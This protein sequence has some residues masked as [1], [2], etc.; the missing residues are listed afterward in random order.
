MPF[1]TYRTS[2][3]VLACVALVG[4]PLQAQ[5]PPPQADAMAIDERWRGFLGCWASSAAGT[6]GP[7]MCLLPTSSSET[8]EMVTVV[9]DSIVS[10]SNVTAS[11]QRVER[12]VDG[13]TGWESGRWSMDERRLYTRSEFTCGNASTQTASGIFAMTSSYGFSRIEGIRTKGGSRVRVMNFALLD[14]AAIPAAITHRLPQQNSMPVLAARIESAAAVRLSDVT[15]A[16]QQVD[17]AVVEAWIADRGQPF[18]LSAKT[19]RSLRIAGVSTSIID[20]MVAVSHPETF[21]VAAG[22]APNARP[23]QQLRSGTDAYALANRRAAYRGGSLGYGAYSGWGDQYFP[24]Y[25]FDGLYGLGYWSPY[26]NRFGGFNN[27]G[28]NGYYNG[29][30][31]GGWLQG[32]SPYVIVPANPN[33]P[34]DSR[35]SVVN[36]AGYSQNGGSGSS[37]TARPRFP[38]SVQQSGGYSQGGGSSGVSTSTG[39]GNSSAGGGDRTAKPRP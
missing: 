29:F 22:G 9:G 34:A 4:A 16:A 17:T 32:G 26:G 13:C 2:T 31:G 18:S 19:L 8:V 20:M 37:G 12:T 6:M 33:P 35:G 3:W 11:G 24:W 28:Y 15:E 21:A 30:F 39:G 7:T 1:P 10:R 14:T 36:G 25:A 27:F 5:Q 38:E 23:A